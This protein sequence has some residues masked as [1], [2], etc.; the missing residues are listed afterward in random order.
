MQLR[1]DPDLDHLIPIF[2]RAQPPVIFAGT[3]SHKWLGGLIGR[4]PR[5]LADAILELRDGV[6]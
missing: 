3:Q 1:P 2:E 5:D 6:G 4:D